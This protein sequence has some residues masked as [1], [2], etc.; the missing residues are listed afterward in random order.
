MAYFLEIPEPCNESWDQMKPVDKGRYC[1]VCEK[2]IYD[3]RL[4][5]DQEIIDKIENDK[6]LCAIYRP[7]QLNRPLRIQNRSVLSKFGIFFSLTALALSN[8]KIN[9]QVETV[10]TDS[11]QKPNKLTKDKLHKF[12]G[13]IVLKGNVFV[14]DNGYNEPV[15]GAKITEE[16]TGS[17]TES[18][19]NGDFSLNL[20]FE[21]P[22]DSVTIKVE[23]PGFLPQ[24]ITTTDPDQ[25]INIYLQE[26]PNAKKE[27]MVVGQ[28]VVKKRNIFSRIGD[29]FRRKKKKTPD[30]IKACKVP[31]Q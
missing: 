6:D 2:V 12:L 21:K 18:G 17:S 7:E 30:S 29:L 14:K 25:I 5:S 24:W 19:F 16:N 8:Q 13:K 27:V 26:D 11:I 9:A 1:A 23:V 31:N 28:I 3:F 22:T 15:P 20:N 4:L 10:K